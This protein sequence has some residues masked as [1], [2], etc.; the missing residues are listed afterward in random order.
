M[1]LPSLARKL[2]LIAPIVSLLLSVVVIL[3]PLYSFVKI[4]KSVIAF[5]RLAIVSFTAQV[6]DRIS[7]QC[8]ISFN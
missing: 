3:Y 5:S 7:R 2:N 6:R 1:L 8:Y 4:E